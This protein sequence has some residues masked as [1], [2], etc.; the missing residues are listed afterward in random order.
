MR[1]IVRKRWFFVLMIAAAT[2]LRAD[3]LEEGWAAYNQENYEQAYDLFSEA[4]REN[5]A[6]VRANFALGEAAAKRG[7]YSHAVFAYDR[8]LMQ[9][10]AHQKARYGKA[11]ALLAL[12]QE[13][14]ARA[15]YAALLRMDLDPVVR[16]RVAQTV[17]E[18]D[19]RN[20]EVKLTGELSVSVFYD[21]NINFGPANDGTLVL[22]A[23][24]RDDAWGIEAGAGVR[25]EVDVG[26]KG[27]W[28]AL[29]SA[30][31]L[32][33]WHDSASAQELRTTKLRAGARKLEQRNLYEVSGRIEM[34]NYD[35]DS[36]VDIYGLDGVWLYAKTRD[37]YLI[38]RVTIEHRDYDDGVDPDNDRDS[39]Y[40]KAGQTWKHFFENRRN[41]LSLG[42]DLFTEEAERDVWSNNGFRLRIDGERELPLGIVAYAGGRY[43][44]TNYED[45][46]GT[47]PEREDHRF[48]L[49][50]GARRQIAKNLSLDLRHQYIRNDSNVSVSDYKRHRTALTATLKF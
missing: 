36:L 17:K 33:S 24:Q 21:D 14:D 26:Q 13:A 38:T 40:L 48:D 42:A 12:G 20:R 46:F 15:E 3:L 4:F 6:D 19:G 44:L 2:G 37:D 18:I 30:S 32:N 25:A 8:V 5:P 29:G 41:T 49:I 7:K 34:L 43:R 28:T 27:G 22:P 23:N 16:E 47:N 35:H 39:I 45:A 9:E 50:V 1:E 31:V 11:N 10:P